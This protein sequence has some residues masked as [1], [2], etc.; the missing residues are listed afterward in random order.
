MRVPRRAFALAVFLSAALL[1]MVEPMVGKMVLPILG[2]APA[3][4]TTC[5]LFFQIALLLGYLYAHLLPRWL[6]ARHVWVHLALLAL[7]TAALP[8]ALPADPLPAPETWT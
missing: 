2:G 4:W 7:A 1:F 5:L 6:G 8:L 3:V